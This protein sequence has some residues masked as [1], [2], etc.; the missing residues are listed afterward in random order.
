[1]DPLGEWGVVP[2]HTKRNISSL[3]RSP[4]RCACCPEDINQRRRFDLDNSNSQ[5]WWMGL[6]TTYSKWSLERAGKKNNRFMLKWD[7]T[8]SMCWFLEDVCILHRYE[9]PLTCLHTGCWCSHGRNNQ[10]L[11]QSLKHPKLQTHALFLQKIWTCIYSAMIAVAV[12][13]AAQIF[14]D[15]TCVTTSLTPPL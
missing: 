2:R 10:C 8:Q 13:S 14:V 5:P 12:F 11:H 9:H 6:T 15:S 4:R 7:L 1:M 3:H